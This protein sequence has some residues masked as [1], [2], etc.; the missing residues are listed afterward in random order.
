MT[1]QSMLEG[2]LV[3]VLA[4]WSGAQLTPSVGSFMLAI[5]H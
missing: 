1:W 3:G 4:P 2:G 5:L